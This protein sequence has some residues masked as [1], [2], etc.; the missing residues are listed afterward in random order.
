MEVEDNSTQ[1]KVIN[2]S[3]GRGTAGSFSIKGCLGSADG[4]IFMSDAR[5][6]V[7]CCPGDKPWIVARFALNRNADK[8]DGHDREYRQMLGFTLKNSCRPVGQD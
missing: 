8:I 1:G 2:V 4:S 3:V 5:D 7:K 6:K